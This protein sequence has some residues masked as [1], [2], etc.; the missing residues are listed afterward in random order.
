M[1]QLRAKSYFCGVVGVVGF[2]VGRLFFAGAGCDL[3]EYP[4]SADEELGRLAE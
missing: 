1:L 4:L 3:F 2:G